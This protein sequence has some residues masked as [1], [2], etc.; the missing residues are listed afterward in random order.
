MRVL[1]VE[2]EPQLLRL[3]SRALREEGYAV[4]EAA[5]GDE[6]LYKATT[7]DYDCVILDLMIPR[8]DGIQVLERLRQT[9]R[10]PVLILTAR[11][12]IADRVRGLDAGGDDYLVKP[13]DL[14]ELFARVRALVRRASGQ[15]ASRIELG[16]IVVDTSSRSVTCAGEPMPL[17]AREYGLVELLALHKGELVTRS[18]IYDHLFDENSDTL[19]NLVDVHVANI[20]RKLG[21][22]FIQTRRGLGYIVDG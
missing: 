15:A 9:K 18:Q 12:A 21:R 4:D 7:W 10:T 6:A 14:A 16:D 11:D 2:D 5:D 3:I 22:D 17:T 1:A 13:F 20:R 8:I 19:S